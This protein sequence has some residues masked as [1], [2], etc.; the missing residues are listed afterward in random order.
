[1]PRVHNP[2]DQNWLMLDSQ[3]TP[4]HV[5]ALLVFGLA[6]NADADPMQAVFDSLRRATRV[7]APWNYRLKSGLRP[8]WVASTEVDLA[9]HVRHCALSAPGG[10]RELGLLVSRLH[11]QALD[12]GLPPWECHVIEGLEG[13]RY[14]LYLKMHGALCDV[15]TFRQMLTAWLT[16][17][18]EQRQSTAPWAMEQSPGVRAQAGE[19]PG[20]TRRNLESMG[21]AAGS[22]VNLGRA[23]MRLLRSGSKTAS[24]L[25]APYRVPRSALNVRIGSQ[26]R[27]A[28]QQFER[29]RL[30][31]AADAFATTLDNLL[32]YLY[33]TALRR[34][35][36]EYNALPD[37]A[38]VAAMPGIR[39]A[40]DGGGANAGLP[41]GSI[42]FISLATQL[43]DPRKRLAEITAS[44]RAAD[45]HLNAVTQDL[46][47]L[48]TLATAAPFLL[49]Q[50]SGLGRLLPAIGNLVIA[51]Q[52]GPE[53]PLYHN[54]ARME[55]CYPLFPLTQKG[56]LSITCL[57]YADRLNIGLTGA[58]EALPHLQRLAVYM[59]VALSDLEEL[60]AEEPT[61]A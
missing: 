14:A 53:Q 61:H 3:A 60:L 52:A 45:E 27:V 6:D 49:G 25:Q 56:A 54:G 31:R 13:G 36:K 40:S 16:S 4:M 39:Q 29:A 43:A 37:D 19:R 11:S 18:P 2:L 28:T 24:H 17:D 12:S 1:M 46:I 23:F 47:P 8:R 50:I 33:A 7:V 32:L 10:E 57:H 9:Y 59:E 48:Y 5:G 15:S 51:D 42:A 38:L 55:A 26:R 20:V 44:A 30:Q 22:A 41:Y 35:F 58:H 34:F 21:K